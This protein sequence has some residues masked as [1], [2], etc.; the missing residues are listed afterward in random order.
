MTNRAATVARGSLPLGAG[1]VP[2]CSWLDSRANSSDSTAIVRGSI[3][4]SSTICRHWGAIGQ[5]RSSSPAGTIGLEETSRAEECSPSAD[6]TVG[7]SASY[8]RRQDRGLSCRESRPPV[9]FS[10]ANQRSVRM[11]PQRHGSDDLPRRRSAIRAADLRAGTAF[12]RGGRN[13]APRE[14]SRAAPFAVGRTSV[15]S[16]R[17]PRV[18]WGERPRP[19]RSRARRALWYA[20]ARPPVFVRGRGHGP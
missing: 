20:D 18:E 1:G 14:T 15:A 8:Y 3:L 19:S 9:V 4:S 11:G 5:Y 10:S 13:T 2:L 7:T 6:S 17:E 16:F 12:P